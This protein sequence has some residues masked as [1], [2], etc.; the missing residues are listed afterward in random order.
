MSKN[1]SSAQKKKSVWTI[2][3][4][5]LL[6]IV[7]GL[8]AVLAFAYFFNNM[9]TETVLTD[10]GND[11]DFLREYNGIIIGNL[12][13]QESVDSWQNI[14]D[15]YGDVVIVIEDSSNV[16]VARSTDR[17]W[18]AVDVKVRTPFEFEGKA[19]VV[20]SSV[21]LLRDY[22]AEVRPMVRF[23]FVEF[24]IG[25]AAFLLILLIIYM[26]MLRPYR[27]VYRAIEAYDQGKR[28]PDN[29]LKGYAGIVFRRFVSLTENL[30]RQQ[31]Q[32]KRIIASISHD[33]KTPLTSIMGYAERLKKREISEERKERYLDTVYGKS[34]E[35]RELLDEFD[36]YL[37]AHTHTGTHTQKITCDEFC[38][39]IYKEYG[40]ELEHENVSFSVE[41][42]GKNAVM[43][44]DIQKMKRVFGN[45]FSNSVKHFGDNNRIILLEVN[46]DRDTVY[47]HISDSGEGVS[48]E[49]MP[50]IFEPFYTSDEGRK[51]AG[52]G[53][54]ICREIVN[55]HD[56]SITAGR[57]HFDG[58]K[59][60]LEL[61]RYDKKTFPD[62]SKRI[63]EKLWH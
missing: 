23:L 53:L 20:A 46:C 30:E 29:K 48:E 12:T 27:Q 7:I 35:I 45:I 28:L 9:V 8:A 10:A 57:S 19:Y 21:Y 16:V 51:V 55:A 61:P 38:E 18:T 43:L 47:I 36:E 5:N 44:M 49:K 54:S 33:I 34:V 1:N 41:N 22:I 6:L 32:Q 15:S 3:R 56:G 39:M 62:T 14:V 59:I 37:G 50:M 58:L 25:A 24:L 31:Q 26:I 11:R 60:S 4:M 17:Y 42:F 13:Q 63:K 40:D 2:R 52:L